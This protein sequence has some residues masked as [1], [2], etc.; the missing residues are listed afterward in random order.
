M[1]YQQFYV[2]PIP[3]SSAFNFEVDSLYTPANMVNQTDNETALPDPWADL[4]P[5]RA[6]MWAKHYE[7]SYED[8]AIFEQ[9]YLEQLAEIGG[10]LPMFQGGKDFE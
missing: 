2:M 7:E 6:A 5:L 4:V 3:S 1:G 8:V 9:K 10:A